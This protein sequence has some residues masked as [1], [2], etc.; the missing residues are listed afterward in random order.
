MVEGSPISFENKLGKFAKSAVKVVENNGIKYGLPGAAAYLI[1]EITN[2]PK[3]VALA[4][5]VEI[6]ALRGISGI[7]NEAEKQ[8]NRS[9]IKKISR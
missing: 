6:L 9:N 3:W 8:E 4:I 2:D 5:G 7:A 1:W